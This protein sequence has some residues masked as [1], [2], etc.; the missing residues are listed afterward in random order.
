METG[1]WGVKEEQPKYLGTSSCRSHKVSVDASVNSQVDSSDTPWIHS[2]AAFFFFFLLTLQKKK[3]L[4][5][6]VHRCCLV[7]NDLFKLCGKKKKEKLLKVLA[8]QRKWKEKERQKGRAGRCL[9][10]MNPLVWPSDHSFYGEIQGFSHGCLWDCSKIGFT[11]PLQ[12]N[13]KYLH[14]DAQL[15]QKH[16]PQKTTKKRMLQLAPCSGLFFLT[17]ITLMFL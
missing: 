11:F 7:E 10:L 4:C 13:Y 9:F 15:Y 5:L 2:F 12:V 3:S 1:D 16:P 6:F 8:L 14:Q 17:M